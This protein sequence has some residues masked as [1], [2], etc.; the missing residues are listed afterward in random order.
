MKNEKFIAI[1]ASLSV[2]YK[3]LISRNVSDRKQK[4]T[5]AHSVD[6]RKIFVSLEKYF[7]RSIYSKATYLVK[8]LIS[9][10]F[11]LKTVICT[12]IW[13]FSLMLIWQK[14]RKSNGFTTKQLVSRNNYPLRENY[15]SFHSSTY[16]KSRSRSKTFREINS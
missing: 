15:L 9:R 2:K 11:C 8:T 10:N 13:K 1:L 14:F 7:V 6:E 16:Y 3:K 4:R 5:L 12:K